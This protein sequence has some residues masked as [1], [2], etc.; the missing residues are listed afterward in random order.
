MTPKELAQVVVRLGKAVLAD[1]RMRAFFEDDTKR[2]DATVY[3]ADFC[4][5]TPGC[6]KPWASFASGWFVVA[7]QAQP[8][9]DVA[10]TIEAWF[11]A[12]NIG[13]RLF[14]SMNPA[15]WPSCVR[16]ALAEELTAATS[17]GLFGDG[18]PPLV[19]QLQTVNSAQR[20]LGHNDRGA[21]F[22]CDLASRLLASGKIVDARIQSLL[23]TRIAESSVL[24]VS[25]AKGH[26]VST[27][28]VDVESDGDGSRPSKQAKFGGGGGS[29]GGGFDELTIAG[30]LGGCKELDIYEA[31]ARAL[32]SHTWAELLTAVQVYNP[33]ARMDVEIVEFCRFMLLKAAT[34]DTRD[35]IMLAPA[36]VQ[37]V[38]C[39]A[40]T[41]PCWYTE[42]CA[43]LLPAVT[44]KLFDHNPA[45]A[46]TLDASMIESRR[47]L[48]ASYYARA[49]ACSPKWLV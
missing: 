45:T 7:L 13:K 18:G 28:S 20:W 19:F 2:R 27:N 25:R 14:K 1:D 33:E 22:M 43:K 34:L 6:S 46:A 17:S 24:S 41:F 35:M 37:Q 16:K 38:W 30:I 4:A 49:F 44:R 15:S 21:R 8:E 31:G 32:V 42:L 5:A 29:S 48:T 39:T 36:A 12:N 11:A 47:K 26:A 23:R 9:G 10:A 3:L 40:M